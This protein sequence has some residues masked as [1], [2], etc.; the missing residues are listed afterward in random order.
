MKKKKPEYL[1]NEKDIRKYE[2]MLFIEKRTL[3]IKIYKNLY[4]NVYNLPPAFTQTNNAGVDYYIVKKLN[5]N[6][7]PRERRKFLMDSCQQTNGLNNIILLLKQFE[8][9]TGNTY[10]YIY[11]I[12]VLR[13]SILI[14][15]QY[16]KKIP[17]IFLYT[18]I[19]IIPPKAIEKFPFHKTLDL[20]QLALEQ[21]CPELLLIQ[22]SFY[23]L[24]DHTFL[25]LEEEEEEKEE[26]KEEEEEEEKEEDSKLTSYLLT[27]AMVLGSIVLLSYGLPPIISWFTS[28]SS[29]KTT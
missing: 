27:G 7:I 22:D 24:K 15:K 26:E 19:F 6:Y 3:E 28:T 5:E 12:C 8:N 29:N 4:H 16:I 10:K 11:K 21:V 18:S 1:L 20:L 14:D 9:Y 13:E 2:E 25:S 17:N 23:S